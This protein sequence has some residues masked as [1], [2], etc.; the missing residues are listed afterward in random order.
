[1]STQKRTTSTGTTL[2]SAKEDGAETVLQHKAIQMVILPLELVFLG[3]FAIS[4]AWPVRQESSNVSLLS[5]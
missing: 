5:L 4:L 3:L 2:S 1:M